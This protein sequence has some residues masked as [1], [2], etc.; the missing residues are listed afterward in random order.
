[1]KMVEKHRQRLMEKLN[2]HTTAGLASYAIGEGVLQI[3]L[4]RAAKRR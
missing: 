2:I 3:D 4:A 1:M